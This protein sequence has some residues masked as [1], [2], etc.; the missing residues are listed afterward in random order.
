MVDIAI[1]VTGPVTVNQLDPG[2]FIG[3]ILDRLTIMEALMSDFTTFAANVSTQLDTFAAG[4]TDIAADVAVLLTKAAQAGIF[5]AEEQAV[6][7]GVQAKFDTA[8]ANLSALNDQVGDQDGSD[9]P[10]PPAEPTA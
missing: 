2:A 7:D 5:T 8:H 4:L 3:P 1:T 9:T 6:A 10:P